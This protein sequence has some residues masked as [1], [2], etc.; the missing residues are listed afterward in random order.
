MPDEQTTIVIACKSTN[1]IQNV[2]AF[3][4]SVA[5]ADRSSAEL[6]KT[7]G[8][9]FAGSYIARF[10][11][12]SVAAFSATEEA[13]NRFN[14]TYRNSLG[15]A[16]KSLEALRSE[17]GLSERSANDMLASAGDLLTGFGF[18]SDAALK[19]SE[20][21]ARLGVDLYSF[22]NYA[23]GAKG[24]TDALVAAMLGET[25]RAKAL[26]IVIR[27]DSA[28]YRGMVKSLMEA[29]GYTLD[30]AK[31][32]TALEMAY[33]QS[34]NAIGDWNRP[35]ETYAQVV[36]ANAEL[37]EQFRK[38]I[39]EGLAPA[40]KELYKITNSVLSTFNNLDPQLR[41][42][43]VSIGMGVATYAAIK[44]AIGTVNTVSSIR[45]KLIGEATAQ[46]AAENIAVKSSIAAI[47]EQT[48]ALA[49]N[50]AVRNKQVGSALFTDDF[51]RQDIQQRWDKRFERR[52]IAIRSRALGESFGASIRGVDLPNP[53]LNEWKKAFSDIGNNAAVAIPQLNNLGGKFKDIKVPNTFRQNWQDAREMVIKGTSD[54]S[55]S[56]KG[57][58]KSIRGLA[59][60]EGAFN[61][62]GNSIT[63]VGNAGKGL[64]GILTGGAGGLAGALSAIGAGFLAWEVWKGGF[65]IGESIAEKGNFSDKFADMFWGVDVQA[66][67]DEQSKIRALMEGRKRADEEL[68]KQEEALIAAQRKRAEATEKELE[69]YKKIAASRHEYEFNRAGT[70]EQLSMARGEL[71]TT[72][73][74]IADLKQAENA[75]KDATKRIEIYAKRVELTSKYYD[76]LAKFED[77][78]S[79]L[80]EEERSLRDGF[81]NLRMNAIGADKKALTQEALNNKLADANFFLASGKRNAAMSSLQ[82]AQ[83]YINQIYERQQQEFQAAMNMIMNHNQYR[84]TAQQ[85]IES[86]TL[87]ARRLESRRFDAVGGDI[88]KQMAD[89]I[90]K[91]TQEI[92]EL[93]R[94]IDSIALRLANGKITVRLGNPIAKIGG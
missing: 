72:S 77:T 20:R 13:A 70:G 54:F 15:D 56:L 57:F 10:G 82:E 7:L 40:F 42:A 53:Q 78:R 18:T 47:R 16:Q 93:K 33:R 75:E 11:K 41:S 3:T 86:G 6:M 43:V 8:G 2:N 25:E 39:G 51:R 28:E 29:K 71:Y 67:E 36:Q 48:A 94:T 73:F 1:A 37:T 90:K 34:V 44:T 55:K 24:A 62:V 45:N 88:Q 21:A 31:A 30:M 35:G 68:Q 58:G 38:N 17:F 5:R 52:G 69:L 85:V 32:E 80:Q 76:Q 92:T 14:V 60:S 59:T 81:L 66:F 12:Q 19:L 27:Q 83:S 84:A 9:L 26:G 91:N 4:D 87:E 65:A 23:G 64:I 50:Q 79:K 46:Q 61:A 22:T 89:D 49:A 63:A 74:Q